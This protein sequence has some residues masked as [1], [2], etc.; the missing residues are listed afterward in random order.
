MFREGAFSPTPAV[1]VLK[2]QQLER[3]N[4]SLTSNLANLQATLE[5]Q[6]QLAT[7]VERTNQEESRARQTQADQQKA[8]VDALTSQV[9][10]GEPGE[11][12]SDDL[13]TTS[14]VINASFIRCRWQSS[15]FTRP[16]AKA[17]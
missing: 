2:M 12:R 5:H 7:L 3:E 13:R 10:G 11:E 14:N 6:K 17:R 4:F 9:R 16:G 15:S 8:L 1:N